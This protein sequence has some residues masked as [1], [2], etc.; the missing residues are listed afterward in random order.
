MIE[1][2]VDFDAMPWETAEAGFRYKA[3]RG[4][5]CQLRMVEITREFVETEWCEKCHFGIV[6]EGEMVIDFDG[7]L[8]SYKQG[9]GVYI[10]A[11]EGNRHKAKALTNVARL[12]FAEKI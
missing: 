11:G 10:P 7:D 6:L 5:E 12:V 8:V 4:L 9:D 3:F 1:H 2:K